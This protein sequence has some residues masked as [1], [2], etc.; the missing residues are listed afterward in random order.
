MKETS[1]LT[2]DSHRTQHRWLMAF[3]IYTL[4]VIAWGAWVRISHSGDGCG[5][6][7]PH[8]LGE[9]I[10]LGAEKKTWIEYSHR[11]MSGL[12][13]LLAL[14]IFFHFRQLRYGSLTRKL[15]AAV[16]VL[17]LIEAGLGALLVKRGLVTVDDSVE[18]LLVMSLH[19]LNS[20]LLTGVSFLLAHSVITPLR[21]R[22]SKSTFAFIVVSMTGAIAALSTTL[23]PTVSLLEG[24]LRD[25][26]EDSHIFVRLRILHPVLALSLM[27]FLAYH[28]YLKGKARLALEIFGALL[29][30]VVTLMTLSPVW[31]KL[32]HLLL[33]HYLWARICL[34]VF[35]PD[36][37][38]ATRLR[39]QSP[40]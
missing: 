32:T 24:I 38:S 10:P 25:F 7:W 4:V 23:F 28:F 16:F 29:V 3:W 36:D 22:W 19:Q 39:T 21:W 40:T 26:H 9:L 8:C 12:Y 30:G 2:T 15:S 6:H 27:G 34:E 18:R 17:M 33:A 11:L 13:G 20:F 35:L 5:D 31:L 1:T 37:S 14:A